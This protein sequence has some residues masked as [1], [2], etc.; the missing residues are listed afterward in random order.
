[1]TVPISHA[2][3]AALAVE[4]DRERLARVLERWDVRQQRARIDVDGMA[5]DRLHDRDAG[6][7][8]RLAEIRGG[9]DPVA[10]VVLVDDLAEALR[11]R[12]EIAAGEAAVRGE[13]LGEDQQVAALLGELRRR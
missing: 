10:E 7:G 5:A 4:R 9:A 2:P 3:D 1:M 6:A 8:K 12:L 11:D 13:A